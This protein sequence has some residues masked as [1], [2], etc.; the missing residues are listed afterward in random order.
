MAFTASL[1]KMGLPA[2]PSVCFP[3]LL[4]D[5]MEIV[6]RQFRFIPSVIA[7]IQYIANHQIARGSLF[8]GQGIQQLRSLMKV[9]PGWF[10]CWLSSQQ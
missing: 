6:S 9:Q 4:V 8:P 7:P 10:L 1:Q 2:A 3:A 5:T